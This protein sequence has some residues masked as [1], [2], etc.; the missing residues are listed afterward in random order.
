MRALKHLISSTFGL[1]LMLGSLSLNAESAA[2]VKILMETSLGNIELELYPEKAPQTV[3]NFLRYADEGFYEGTIF[4]RVINSFMI[5]G[6]GFDAGL[7]KK[8]THASIQNEADNGLKNDRGTIAMA[9]TSEPNSAT[10][11][12]FIN[13]VDNDFLN[14]TNKSFKG[15]GYCVFGKV[16]SGMKT[17]D[18]IAD[19]FTST[20]NRMQNVPEKTV[21]IK[22]VSRL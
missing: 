18:A 19:V 22:K 2:P 9:R 10:S 3:E 14:H 21:L 7:K 16:T 1:L 4:H 12:F 8:S 20:Q 6:G 17:V 13:H 11:Q 5:Q 15:W